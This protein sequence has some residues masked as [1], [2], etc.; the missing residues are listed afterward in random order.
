M[1][2]PGLY[3][4]IFSQYLSGELASVAEPLKAIENLDQAGFRKTSVITYDHM[5]HEILNETANG[6][7]YQDLLDFFLDRSGSGNSSTGN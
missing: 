1:I 7:V 6:K 4:Q 2:K 3:E 5:R